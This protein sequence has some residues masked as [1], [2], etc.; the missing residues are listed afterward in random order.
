MGI[1]SNSM[2]MAIAFIL[3]DVDSLK[4]MNDTSGHKIGDLFGTLVLT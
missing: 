4:W 3:C 2:C 1:A